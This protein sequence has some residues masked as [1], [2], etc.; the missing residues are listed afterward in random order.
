[1]GR[2]EFLARAGKAGI[3]IAAAG[4]ISYKLYDRQGPEIGVDTESLVTLP[5]FSTPYKAGQTISVVKGP[6]RVK[7]VN[8][9]IELLG[10]IERFVK[11]GET[12]AIKPN[13]AFAS[14]PMLGATANPELVAEVVKLCYKGGAKKVY[15]F[16]HTVSAWERAYK[17]SGIQRAAEAVGAVMV[18]ANS[19][20][21][22]ENVQVPGGEKLRTTDVHE[23]ILESDVFINVPVL[24]HHNSTRITM[25]MKNLMG[26]VWNRGAFHFQGLNQCIADFPLVRKPD[27]NVLDA[28]VVTL[29]HGPGYAGPGDIVKKKNLLLSRDIVAIDTAG[30]LIFG[31]K[32][33]QIR[34]LSMARDHGL[35][36]MNLDSL[37]IE[38]IAL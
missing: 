31:E 15:V 11:E 9:A 7:T 10:G 30:T 21:Y 32:P 20:R 14:P 4:A 17:S 29:R 12:V 2:R 23:L 38:R 28:Y 19:D 13:V 5:D 26:V 35:G 34:Y 8:K 36:I 33:E 27:L 1:M 16:D 18:P 24:K 22:Y 37:D 6:D 3:S 25:A